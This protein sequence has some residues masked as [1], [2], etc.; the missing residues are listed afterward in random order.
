M[1]DIKKPPNWKSMKNISINEELKNELDTLFTEGY[2]D[3]VIEIREKA[4]ELNYEIVGE[5]TG[6]LVLSSGS[7]PKG[8]IA[9]IAKGQRGSMFNSNEGFA[10][11]DSAPRKIVPYLSPVIDSQT[12]GGGWLISTKCNKGNR[13]TTNQL[14]NVLEHYNINYDKRELVDVNVGT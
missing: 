2:F 5:G 4:K 3:G 6:R 14:R 10:Y 8:T 9:K 1:T 13:Q 12:G 7:L 11:E